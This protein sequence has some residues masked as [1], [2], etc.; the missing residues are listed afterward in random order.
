MSEETLQERYLRELFDPR[1]AL[2]PREVAARE[3]ILA[4]REI[5]ALGNKPVNSG[6]KAGKDSVPPSEVKRG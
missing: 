5:I 6:Q 4:L 3:E 1:S 2:T